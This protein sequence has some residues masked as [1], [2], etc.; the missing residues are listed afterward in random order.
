MPLKKTSK[1]FQIFRIVSSMK[2]QHRLSDIQS[3]NRFFIK[4]E[5]NSADVCNVVRNNTTRYHSQPVN[6]YIS[7]VYWLTRI[8][9]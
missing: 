8:I 9:L 3:K 6:E 5:A 4:L 7:T 2:K 1:R